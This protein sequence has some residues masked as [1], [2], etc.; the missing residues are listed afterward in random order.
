MITLITAIVAGL[1]SFSAFHWAGDVG[2]GWS[3][4]WAILTFLAI[5]IGLGVFFMRKVKADM[6]F[7]QSIIAEAQKG[8]EEK[9][10][11]WQLRPPGSIQEAQRIIQ[12]DMRVAVKKALVET[13]R[14]D[15]YRP[16]VLMV[17]KQVATARMH[18]NWM[19]KDFKAVD[20]LMPKAFIIDPVSASMKMARMQMLGKSIEEIDKVYRKAVMRAR[21][22]DNVL[23]AACYSW[24]LVK[25]GDTDAAFKVLGE[26]LKKSDNE[27]LKRNHEALMNNRVLHFNNSGIGDQ[28]YSLHLEEPKVK[29]AR[30]RPV[31]R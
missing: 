27:T 8:V 16:W 29:A 17:A 24:I 26:A 12:E 3:I 21:Y 31:Y 14:L 5:Q 1:G 10:R 30:Q 18:L 6:L 19:I 20:E 13:S 25:R 23:P 15:K 4:T 2:M 9:M 28:W 7:V 11:R 22:N